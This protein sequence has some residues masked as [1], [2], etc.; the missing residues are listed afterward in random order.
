ML[1]IR[2]LRWYGNTLG[3]KVIRRS[4]YDYVEYYYVMPSIVEFFAKEKLGL[5]IANT[6]AMSSILFKSNDE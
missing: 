2:R 4:V 1:E 3:A 6:A 5:T